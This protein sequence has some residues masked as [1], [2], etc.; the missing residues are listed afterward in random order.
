MILDKSSVSQFIIIE[1]EWHGPYLISDILR[2]DKKL[3]NEI[4]VYQI[5]GN[6]PINGSDNLLYIGHTLKSFKARLKQHY[7]V[8]IQHESTDNQIYLG[9]IWE[10]EKFEPARKELLIKESEKLLT[11]YSSPPYNS[12]LVYD[13]NQ[14]EQFKDENIL[15]INLWQKHRLPYEV[16]SSWYYSTC[17]NSKRRLLKQELADSDIQHS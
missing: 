3:F 1:I 17:W 2:G 14:S 5:Y 6:H 11:Y 16:S 9:V 7:N 10:K 15:V 8:W 13:L 4:G 12:T